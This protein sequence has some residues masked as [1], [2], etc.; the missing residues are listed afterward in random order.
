MLFFHGTNDISG[1]GT[2][3]DHLTHERGALSLGGLNH[4]ICVPRSAHD[5]EFPLSAGGDG[6]II[7]SMPPSPIIAPGLVFGPGS[8]PGVCFLV[9]G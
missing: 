1:I 6:A 2:P 8:G 5:P 9:R 3:Q 7:E 4:D